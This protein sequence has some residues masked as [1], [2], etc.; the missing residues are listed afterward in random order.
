MTVPAALYADFACPFSYVA[1]AALWRLADEGLVALACRAFE[2]WPA[3]ARLPL[4]A[5]AEW[6]RAAPL[7]EA[8]GLPFAVPAVRSRTRKAH[9]A[10][11]FAAERGV[12][13]AFREAVYR[14]HWAEGRDVGRIDV[15]AAL[16]AGVGLD[17]TEAR[18]VLDVDTY[19]EAVAA[20]QD[21]ARRA[22]VAAVPTLELGEGAA[23]RT[24]T[25]ALPLDE[26]RR[27][28]HEA[29]G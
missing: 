15:L 14:A 29:A 26:L 6:S 28:L 27:A 4:D 21:A 13:R 11:R 2:L 20:E 16:A 7:A 12:E 23:A 5:P 24:V 3:P 18:V 9:E 19:A 22:G 1:E 17:A 10:A 25:G 8:L